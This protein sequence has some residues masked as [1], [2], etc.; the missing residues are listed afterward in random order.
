M[1]AGVAAMD[2]STNTYAVNLAAAPYEITNVAVNFGGTASVSF[3]GYGQPSSGGTV[4]ITGPRHQCTVTLNG[5]T[6]Q[7]TIS[8]VS[9]GNR[10][11]E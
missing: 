1:S 4:I 7:I 11:P 2:S 3:D 5:T 8:R 9:T 6:G 10:A